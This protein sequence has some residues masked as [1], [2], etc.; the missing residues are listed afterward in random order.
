LP[1]GYIAPT[2]AIQIQREADEKGIPPAQVQEAIESVIEEKKSSGR[3]P[4]AS[5]AEVQRKLAS[6][7]HEQV[8]EKEVQVQVDQALSDIKTLTTGF[9]HPLDI[10]QKVVKLLKKSAGV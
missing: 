8:G 1:A 4:K 6:T 7:T 3:V 2:A 9:D 5:S 10:L